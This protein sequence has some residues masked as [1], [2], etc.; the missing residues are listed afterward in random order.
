MATVTKDVIVLVPGFLGSVLEKEGKELWGLSKG[1]LLRALLS[2]GDSVGSLEL[3][4]DGTDEVASDGITAPRLLPDTHLLPGLWKVD[5]Y[6][7]VSETLVSRFGLLRGQNYF[8]FP[9]DWRRDVRPTARRLA[10]LAP[11]WLDHWRQSLGGSPDSRLILVGHSLG[12]L[13]S[14]YFLEVLGGWRHTRALITFGTPHRGSLIAVDKLANGFQKKLGP[15]P[16]VDLTRMV[17]SLPPVYQLLPRYPCVGLPDGSVVRPTEAVGVPH[18]DLERARQGREFM[19]EIDHAVEANLKDEEYL[20]RGYLLHPVVGIN[21]PT[22]QGARLTDKGVEMLYTEPGGS[23]PGGDGTVPR[24]SA[25]PLEERHHARAMYSPTPHASLQNAFEVLAH[26]EG[27]LTGHELLLSKYRELRGPNP[28]QLSLWVEDAYAH[29]EPVTVRVRPSAE[30]VSL[31]AWLTRLETG[32]SSK[33]PLERGKEGW[34]EGTHA[35]LPPGVYRL[36]VKGGP[37]VTPVS[38]VLAV[39]PQS[40][41]GPLG[42]PEP[43]PTPDEELRTGDAQRAALSFEAPREVE[44][45]TGDEAHAI[46]RTPSVEPLGPARAGQQLS[47][48][49]DLKL[50]SSHDSPTESTGF[51]LSGLDPNWKQLPVEVHVACPGMTFGEGDDRGV[52]LVRRDQKSVA[53]TLT[54]MI[55][56]D[57]KGELVAMVTFEHNGRLCGFARRRIAVEAAPAGGAGTSGP[58]FSSSS[59]PPAE[60]SMGTRGEGTQGNMALEV[61]A[62]A[63][64]LTVYILRSESSG[65][66]RLQWLLTVPVE[67]EGLP[68]RMSALV[69]VGADGAAFFRGV[70]AAARE[71]RPG[72]HY[73]WFQGLGKLLYERTPPEFRQA[74]QA[75]R[76][77]YGPGFPIQLVTN[78]PHIPWELMLPADVPGADLLCLEHPVGRWLLD[79]QTWMT[80]RLPRGDILTVAPDYTHHPHLEPLPQAQVESRLLQQR[81]NAQPVRG[82][83]REVLGVLTRGHERPVALLHF[84][85]HGSYSGDPVVPS[86]IFLEDGALLTLEVRSP[87]VLLGLHSRPL[88][89][90]NACEVGASSEVLGSMGG[91]AEAFISQRFGGFI[92]PMWPVQDAHARA[93]AER[94]LADMLEKGL[95]VGEAL[96]SIRA[97]EART[98]PTYLSYVYVGDVLARLVPQAAPAHQG[99]AA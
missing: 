11:A 15:L 56:A 48:R 6:T 10:R 42:L 58:S 67:C 82:R 46:T 88:V 51:T 98:S 57:A 21:Q 72:E 65:P 5:G 64:H 3:K 68:A 13:V 9:Y 73:A 77:R 16:L 90:F 29:D 75:L 12:G 4:N 85:G 43:E 91:W 36:T 71:L 93:V 47:L 28:R 19:L 78:E 30:P 60:G 87:Q 92:A 40:L 52:V 39:F 23:D 18:L 55:N 74:Y 99:A 34:H 50:E 76:R 84:A 33:L 79:Y 95:T 69:D 59:L 27:V 41:D 8:E 44:A 49:V 31:V 24:V 45:G 22:L 26:V 32:E 54:G 63:P 2:F 89:L 20:T 70:A 17:R 61:E 1:A 38:D 97:S 94:L 80:S 81:F 25:M 96:R 53:A 62:A 37:E 7:H 86:R 14:R 83:R 66:Q 35:P